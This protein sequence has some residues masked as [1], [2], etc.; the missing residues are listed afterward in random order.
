[1]WSFSFCHFMADF[2]RRKHTKLVMH[3]L[4]YLYYHGVNNFNW[5]NKENYFLS[6][7]ISLFK[8]EL[9]F[10]N[11]FLCIS[12]LGIIRNYKSSKLQYIETYLSK[13]KIYFLINFSGNRHSCKL[14]ILM[15]EKNLETKLAIFTLL[16]YSFKDYKKRKNEQ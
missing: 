11:I 10:Y 9:K 12:N 2:V 4:F 16:W 6:Q 15:H 8:I 1:M 13:C 7:A 14:E 5:K 3:P